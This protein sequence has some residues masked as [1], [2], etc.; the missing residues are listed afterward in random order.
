MHDA[1]WTDDD[2]GMMMKLPQMMD[3]EGGAETEGVSLRLQ[4]N[5]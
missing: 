4:N 2:S 5:G 1:H 3:G